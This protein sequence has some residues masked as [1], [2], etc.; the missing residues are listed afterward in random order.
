[1]E[2]GWSAH[3]AVVMSGT[4]VPVAAPM[5]RYS[6]SCARR[7]FRQASSAPAT[8]VATAE[9]HWERP[10]QQ[11]WREW[12]KDSLLQISR[13]HQLPREIR[14]C[15]SATADPYRKPAARRASNAVF[16][17]RAHAAR[18]GEAS[19]PPPSGA[20]VDLAARPRRYRPG[21][22]RTLIFSPLTTFPTLLRLKQ[23]PP[24]KRLRKSARTR[25]FAVVPFLPGRD[26]AKPRCPT[27]SL[28]IPLGRVRHPAPRRSPPFLRPLPWL[29]HQDSQLPPLSALLAPGHELQAPKNPS[30]WSFLLSTTPALRLRCRAR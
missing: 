17:S 10:R 24:P 13:F 8:C 29:S 11:R 18:P 1:M 19:L 23:F 16:R 6:R 28:P 12:R 7:H 25:S 9:K 27:S 30:L 3:A 26:P 14:R 4:Q 21:T 20:P 5:S 22:L 2:S 15:P